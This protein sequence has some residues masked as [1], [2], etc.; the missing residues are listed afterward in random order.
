MLEELPLTDRVHSEELKNNCLEKYGVFKMKDKNLN[1]E[2]NIWLRS[3]IMKKLK[4][5][6]KTISQEKAYVR[7]LHDA[8]ALI[9]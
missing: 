9:E 5:A 3:Y 8:L 7:A 2:Y 4:K 1:E 6:E